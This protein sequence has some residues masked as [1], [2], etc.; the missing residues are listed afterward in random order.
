VL[1]A[2]HP[3]A[4]RARAARGD[5]KP[6]AAR[7]ALRRDL[8]VRENADAWAHASGSGSRQGL[9]LLFGWLRMRALVHA[10]TVAQL[11]MPGV[12]YCGGVSEPW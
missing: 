7:V 11:D 9:L 5:V 6:D 3:T 10:T 1:R 2:E 8:A 4:L 12:V